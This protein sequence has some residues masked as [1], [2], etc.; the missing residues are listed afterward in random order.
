[1]GAISGAKFFADEY[2]PHLV[3]GGWQDSLGLLKIFYGE[4]LLFT[5]QQGYHL[6]LN[7]YLVNHHWRYHKQEIE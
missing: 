5:S 7:K 6:L 4:L 3:W 2:Y 1:M